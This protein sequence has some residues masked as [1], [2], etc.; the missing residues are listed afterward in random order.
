MEYVT[1]TDGTD[2]VRISRL[3]MGCEPLGGVDW[4]RMNVADV[5]EAVARSLDLGVT[6]FDTADVYGL[7]ESE[8]ALGTVLGKRARDVVIITKGGVNWRCAADQRATTFADLSPAHVTRAVDASLR[9]LGV[10]SIPLY[11]LHR[12]DPSTPLADTLE[13]LVRCRE[14]GKIRLIGVSNFP[15]P[16]VRAALTH[17]RIAAVQ[18]QYN[19]VDRSAEDA[20]IPACRALELPVL[21][22]GALAQGMLGGQYR[23]DAQFG[24]DDRRHRLPHFADAAR[25]TSFG[26]VRQA[27]DVARSIGRTP[28]QVSIRWVLDQPGVAAAI[29][30]AKH[31]KQAE[32]NAAS[33]DWGLG[34]RARRQLVR[35]YPP[36]DRKVAV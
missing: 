13:A 18:A 27:A 21:A 7:G 26:V 22:Y 15:V 8:R 33:A 35:P 30:G 36:S 11:F 2:H 1:L 10:D 3:I 5:R 29:V 16:L 23:A 28:A 20:L 24:E 9:R 34:E 17:T 31:P 12:P 6:T 4:G 25:R 19:L 32:D 14:A